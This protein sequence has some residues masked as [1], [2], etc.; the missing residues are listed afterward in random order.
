VRV[1]NVVQLMPA[2]AQTVN[3]TTTL[4]DLNNQ[5]SLNPAPFT[6]LPPSFMLRLR[7]KVASTSPT[8]DVFRVDSSG[9]V[10]SQ[11]ELGV[12]DMSITGTGIRMFW[13]PAKVA[14]RAGEADGTGWDASNIG[15]YSFV[16]GLNDT[17]SG[18]V[19]VAFG[20]MNDNSGSF[21]FVAGGNNT[22]RGDYATVFGS[23]NFAE[24]FE[25]FAA[26][27]RAGACGNNTVALGS[28]ATTDP[29][30]TSSQ[31]CSGGDG[32][33]I[34]LLT[35]SAGNQFAARF[36]GGYRFFSNAAMTAGVQVTPGAGS[37]SSLPD[38]NMKENFAPVDGEDLPQRLRNVPVMTW[39][40][41]SQDRSIRHMG[42]MAQDFRAAFGLG[43]D[44]RH[45]ATIDPDGVA[46]ACVQAL[47]ERTTACARRSTRF[48][49][50]TPSCASAWN[51]WRGS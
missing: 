34:T 45:I 38:R 20:Q 28:Y 7:S 19:S 12:G 49:T 3:T 16:A 41:K 40:Y 2:A 50:K 23:R 27:L 47:D 30:G 13:L 22:V 18:P 35:P 8:R 26:G 10:F 33:T 6:V 15:F 32:S 11:G 21:A 29:A 46:L 14:F 39:N 25:P 9:E 42:P 5:R 44:E 17:A 24:G 37:W 51:D 36:N 4:V 31:L 1:S 43:E 48:R